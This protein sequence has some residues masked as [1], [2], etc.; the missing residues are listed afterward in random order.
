[1]FCCH[2]FLHL[3][4]FPSLSKN[5]S[6]SISSGCRLKWKHYCQPKNK[7]RRIYTVTF[8]ELCQIYDGG[9]SCLMKNG[10]DFFLLQF[11]PLHLKKINNSKHQLE[12]LTFY[13]KEKWLQNFILQI[14]CTLNNS[15][16]RN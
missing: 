12:K 9:L 7:M 14:A 2:S 10:N 6:P 13:L 4:M 1:M 5:Q 11:R 3:C 8:T 15:R 16:I